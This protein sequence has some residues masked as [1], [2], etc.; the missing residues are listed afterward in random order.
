VGRR[1]EKRIFGDNQYWRCAP[2][3]AHPH[4]AAVA[5]KTS[6]EALRRMIIYSH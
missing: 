4:T 1:A 5:K 3:C 2:L 6:A